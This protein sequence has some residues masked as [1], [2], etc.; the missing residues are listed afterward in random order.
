MRLT[1]VATALAVFLVAVPTASADQR[2]VFRPAQASQKAF[3]FQL[4]GVSPRKVVRAAVVRGHRRHTLSLRRARAAARHGSLRIRR[5]S[6]ARPPRLAIVSDTRAPQTVLSSGPPFSFGSSE[7]DSTFTCRVDGGDWSACVSPLAL[8][9][10]AG[11]HT[12]SVRATDAAG[13]TDRSP[14]SGSWTV[15]AAPEQPPAADETP[16][17]DDTPPADDGQPAG[18][19]PAADGAAPPAQAP[20]TPAGALFADTFTGLDGVLTNHYAFWSPSD[21]TAFRS[22][23]W[24][25][26]SGCALRKDNTLWSGVPT[27]NIPNRDCSNGSGSEIFRLWTKR[28][29]GDVNVTFSLRNNGYVAGASGARS[30]DGVKVWLRR[31][32]ASGSVGLYTAEVN[33]RQGN[34]LIQKKCAG[35]DEYQILAQDRPQGAA[36]TIGEWEKVGGTVRN[37]ADGSVSLQLIRHGKVVLEATDTGAGCAPLTTAGRVGVR[38]DYTDFNVDDFLVTPAS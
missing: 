25:M 12:L 27:A 17:G 22:P 20:A 9:A 7:A 37:N 30:W 35:S 34:L 23:D 3:T 13:N 18:D 38:G 5:T 26:E 28:S 6:A 21:R 29:Y 14:A 1:G 2:Q 24:E 31:Q 4:R 33:R 11:S 8:D 10:G 15:E 36:A 19:E 16:A 32:G